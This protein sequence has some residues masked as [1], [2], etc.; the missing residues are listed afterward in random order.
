MAKRGEAGE[1]IVTPYPVTDKKGRGGA[2][3]PED[4]Y[5]PEATRHGVEGEIGGFG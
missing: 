1:H 3:K 4:P 5:E 2:T